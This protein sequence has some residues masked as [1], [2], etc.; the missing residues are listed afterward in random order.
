[1]EQYKAA[2]GQLTQWCAQGKLSCHIQKTYPL[3]E[4]ATALKALADRKV[5]GKLVVRCQMSD[6]R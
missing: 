6:D 4:T 2:L 5:M 3:A 1:S